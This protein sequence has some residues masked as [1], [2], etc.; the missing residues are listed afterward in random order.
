MRAFKW[1]PGYSFRL[2][3]SRYPYPVLIPIYPPRFKRGCFIEEATTLHDRGNMEPIY[4]AL[5][6][7][8]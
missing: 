3:S 1:T 6:W 5:V 7:E 4:P 2:A 8:P